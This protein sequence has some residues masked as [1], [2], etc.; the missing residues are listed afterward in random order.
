MTAA[1]SSLHTHTTQHQACCRPLAYAQDLK[2]EC[3]RLDDHGR[4]Q[5]C[6]IDVHVTRGAD[7]RPLYFAVNT[8]TNTSLSFD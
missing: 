5:D 2:F 8:K 1:V 3:P 7:M 4:R 6:R